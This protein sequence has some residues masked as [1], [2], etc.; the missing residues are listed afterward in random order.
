MIKS[1]RR[2]TPPVHRIHQASRIILSFIKKKNRWQIFPRKSWTELNKFILSCRETRPRLKQKPRRDS[3]SFAEAIQIIPGY[4]TSWIAPRRRR[5]GS[6][7]RYSKKKHPLEFNP[8]SVAFPAPALVLIE[9]SPILS[10]NWFPSHL[11][12]I[13]PGRS[14][15]PRIMT[16]LSRNTSKASLLLFP[17]PSL[18]IIYPAYMHCAAQGI[19]KPSVLQS[20]TPC[21]LHN[22]VCASA[23]VHTC[24]GTISWLSWFADQTSRC[25]KFDRHDCNES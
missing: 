21:T 4:E 8:L 17:F 15:P 19:F 20:C 3:E 6:H 7:R 23:F 22:F 24:S 18:S 9:G 10:W 14:R 11:N 2:Y 13:F 16:E 5:E 12:I 25:W 1:A